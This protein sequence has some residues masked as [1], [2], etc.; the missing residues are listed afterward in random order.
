MVFCAIQY[1]R[2]TVFATVMIIAAEAR[3]LE[4][5]FQRVD[6][7]ILTWYEARKRKFQ[8][9]SVVHEPLRNWHSSLRCHFHT[10]HARLPN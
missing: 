8:L 10:M 2:F 6:S 5:F 4:G 9:S 7:E 3:D 1:P